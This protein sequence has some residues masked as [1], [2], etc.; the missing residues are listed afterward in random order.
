[1]RANDLGELLQRRPFVP[2]RLYMSDGTSYE[3]RHPETYILVRSYIAIAARDN[4]KSAVAEHVIFCSL[5][6][7][8][9]AEDI[10][11]QTKKGKRGHSR[12]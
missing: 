7:I 2:M 10:A 3:I 8:V 6:Q 12:V 1:M 5:G 9:R 11:V 4:P